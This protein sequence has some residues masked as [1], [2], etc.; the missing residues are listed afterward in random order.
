MIMPSAIA[1]NRRASAFMPAVIGAPSDMVSVPS[2][3][4]FALRIVWYD[5]E[6]GVRT[7]S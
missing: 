6:N 7:T 1:L 4:V 3:M 5:R 2:R